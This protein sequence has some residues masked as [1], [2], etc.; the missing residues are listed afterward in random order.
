MSPDP[1][2]YYLLKLKLVNIKVYRRRYGIP[3]FVY[4]LEGVGRWR[5]C[6]P[7]QLSAIGKK[8]R[9]EELSHFKTVLRLHN[10]SG[11]KSNRQEL[12][13]NRF[14]RFS[15][16]VLPKISPMKWDLAL[17][18]SSCKTPTNLAA[19]NLGSFIHLQALKKPRLVCDLWVIGS[20]RP[21]LGLNQ[22][23]LTSSRSVFPD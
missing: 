19:Y 9:N 8:A 23:T 10:V 3:A 5:G 6:E 2:K 12:K 1:K 15:S 20:A 14:F 7:S 18:I 21:Q 16:N 17:L 22:G 11:Q 4:I 13:R